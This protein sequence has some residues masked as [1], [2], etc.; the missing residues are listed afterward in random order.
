MNKGDKTEC[1]PSKKSFP[2]LGPALLVLSLG[3]LAEA[4]YYWWPCTADDAFITFRYAQNLVEGLGPVYNPGE[5]VEGYSSPIWMLGSRS[6]RKV[7]TPESVP[8]VPIEQIK[9]SICASVCSQISGPVL[10]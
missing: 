9:P 2:W 7:A 4:A 3:L 6:L 10:R 1:E 8:P 5:R